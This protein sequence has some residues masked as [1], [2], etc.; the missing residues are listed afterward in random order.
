M[1]LMHIDRVLYRVTIGGALSK[2]HR[3]THDRRVEVGHQ[4]RQPAVEHILTSSFE[5]IRVQGL[6]VEFAETALDVMAIYGQ[7]GRDIVLNCWTHNNFPRFF[8]HRSTCLSVGR[9]RTR[10]PHTLCRSRGHDSF[11]SSAFWTC[12]DKQTDEGARSRW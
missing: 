5:V 2:R 6:H 9:H 3:I 8:K 7:H 11:M 4:M 12:R 1:I 10:K